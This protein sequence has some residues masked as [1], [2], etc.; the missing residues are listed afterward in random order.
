MPKTTKIYKQFI[1]IDDGNS[2]LKLFYLANQCEEAKEQ[3]AGPS[4]WAVES[5]APAWNAGL[6]QN[7]Q[8]WKERRRHRAAHELLPSVYH[9]LPQHIPV[10]M[11]TYIQ[12]ILV[13]IHGKMRKQSKFHK[14]LFLEQSCL[15]YF[16]LFWL[17]STQ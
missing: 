3:C 5:T 9:I 12:C 7:A 6:P 1:T 16:C 14:V 15:A 4:Q 11:H 13:Q 17:Y 10:P 2:E 8:R